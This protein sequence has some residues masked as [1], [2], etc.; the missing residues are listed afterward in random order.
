[1][2][3]YISILIPL[4]NG[5]EFLKEC[6]DSVIAQ[7]YGDWEAIIVINGHGDDGG[8]VAVSAKLIAQVDTR[9]RIIVQKKDIRPAG[10]SNRHFFR[11]KLSV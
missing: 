2:R 10:I 7:T 9:I 6:I 11:V 3:P 1:M 8:D 4:Y 5:I